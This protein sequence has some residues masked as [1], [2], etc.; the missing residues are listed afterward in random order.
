MLYNIFKEN[1][2][3]LKSF[4]SMNSSLFK[5]GGVT[6]KIYSRLESEGTT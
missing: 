6:A 1:K 2:S 3:I 5:V 4:C